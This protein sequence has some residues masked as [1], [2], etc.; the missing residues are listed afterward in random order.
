MRTMCSAMIKRLL[1]VVYIIMM[2]VLGI[3]TIVGHAYGTDFITLH[4]YNSWWFSALWTLLAIIGI[5]WIV[6]RKTRRPSVILLHSSFVIILIGAALTHFT[7]Y[8]GMIHLRVGEKTNTFATLKADDG[9]VRERTLPFYITLKRFT[10]TPRNHV[11]EF[12]IDDGN[13][14]ETGKVAMNKI[15]SYKHVRLCQTSYDDGFDGTYLSINHDPYGITVTYIGY[16]ALFL[17]LA[18]M[19]VNSRGTFR[20]L[21]R[22][23]S[24]RSVGLVAV[25]IILM[26]A[27]MLVV[28]L[29]PKV[30]SGHIY[31]SVPFVPTI[32]VINLITGVFLAL[33]TMRKRVP[34]SKTIS[35][36]CMSMFVVTFIALTFYEALVWAVS[37]HMPMTNVYDTMTFT[38][39]TV[40][41]LTAMAYKRFQVALSFGFLLSG[42]FLLT[43]YL[44]SP[45]PPMRPVAPI[46][47][48]PLL[49]I[50]VSLVVIAYALLSFTFICGIAAVVSKRA[51]ARQ[52]MLRHLS[53]LCL[54][55]ALATLTTGIFV[56]AMWANVSWGTYWNWDPKEVWALITLMVY[57]IAAH[58][59]TLPRLKNPIAYHVF[60]VLAFITIVIT[61]LGVSYYLGGIHSYA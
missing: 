5:A 8:Q 16:F 38:A 36:T 23:A 29:M 37:G 33:H 47:S 58:T 49:T 25:A 40:M 59:D 61:F 10:A 39:W 3:A 13:A 12:T 19:L 48:T 17:S 50:H 32:F 60:M 52:E 44:L 11:S 1:M 54:Y 21:L 28:A 43:A 41:V 27:A 45:N 6:K 46:L 22:K 26:H 55:P 57:A 42:G 18:W 15:H 30:L 31:K 34:D 4:V 14:H 35:T 56:G 7:S 9:S 24:S 53:Q 20:H 2:V 51:T